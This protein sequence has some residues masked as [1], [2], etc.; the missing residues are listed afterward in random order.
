MQRKYLFLKI[1]FNAIN[2]SIIV[3][4]PCGKIINRAKAHTYTLTPNMQALFQ[5]CII[6][7]PNW[8]KTFII[9]TRSE[10]DNVFNQRWRMLL[11]L[12]FIQYLIN[13]YIFYLYWKGDLF[14]CFFW[15]I[16]YWFTPIILVFFFFNIKGMYLIF[17]ISIFDY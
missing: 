7:L 6:F 3:V 10:E 15:S 8:F 9:S 17:S 4:G 5:L 2:I 11:S 16:W 1:L 14:R 12:I 13:I